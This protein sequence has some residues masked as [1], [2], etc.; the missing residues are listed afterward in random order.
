MQASQLESRTTEIQATLEAYTAAVLQ[1]GLLTDTNTL[2][3]M[4][5]YALQN[6]AVQN[7]YMLELHSS[8]RQCSATSSRHI[9]HITNTFRVADTATIRL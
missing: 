9:Y 3:S 4:I 1:E 5:A 7:P 6:A 2:V 8:Y